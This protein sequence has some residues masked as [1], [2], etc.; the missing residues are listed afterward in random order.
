[1]DL[2]NLSSQP[3]GVLRSWLPHGLRA[4]RM[5]FLSDACPGKSPLEE[6]LS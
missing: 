4:E 5:V 1:M 2:T 3:E 6:L